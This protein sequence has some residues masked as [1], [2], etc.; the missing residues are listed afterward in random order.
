MR[1]F[2]ELND[3]NFLLFASKNYNNPQCV[4]VEEF[5]DDLARFKYV[6]RLLRRYRQ[7][8]EIQERLILNHLIILYN[9][10]GIPAANKM[11]FFKIE[12]ELWPVIKTFL[13]YLDYISENERVEVPVD[14]KIAEILRKI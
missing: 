10:F 6:K 1:V 11:I 7:S 13:V 2:D 4:D 8:G 14:M 5:N 3:Q 12:P 9:I